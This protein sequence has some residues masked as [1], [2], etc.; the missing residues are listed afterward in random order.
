MPSAYREMTREDRQRLVKPS[1]KV[2]ALPKRFQGRP[3]AWW[4]DKIGAPFKAQIAT[5]GKKTDNAREWTAKIFVT[6]FCD[7]FYKDLNSEER[8][9]YELLIGD[10]VY[11]YLS[12]HTSR[13][14]RGVEPKPPRIKT[15]GYAYERWTKQRPDEYQPLLDAYLDE[16]PDTDI[17]SVGI[18]RKVTSNLFKANVSKEDQ[19]RYREEAR[20]AVKNGKQLKTLTDEARARYVDEFPKRMKAFMQEAETCAGIQLNVQ[21]FAETTNGNHALTTFLSDAIKDFRKTAAMNQLLGSMKQWL[22]VTSGKAVEPGVPPLAVYGDP[23]P[24]GC[25]RPLLP[26]GWPDLHLAELQKL[27]RSWVKSKW[28]HQGGAG[29]SIPWEEIWA[30]V[31]KW[32]DPERLPEGAEWK[33]P[34]SMNVAQLFLFLTYV[35]DCEAGVI[36]ENKQIQFRRVI[37]GSSPIDQSDSQESSREQVTRK[38]KLVYELTFE[39]TVTRCHAPGGMSYP[40]ESLDY[41]AFLVNGSSTPAINNDAPPEWLGLPTNASSVPG[42]SVNPAE[43]AALDAWLWL[44]PEDDRRLA[45]TLLETYKEFQAHLP[46][47]T[48]GGIWSSKSELPALFPSAAPNN[49]LSVDFFADFW[50]PITYYSG[51]RKSLKNGSFLSFEAWI[52]ETFESKALLH[53][54]SSTLHGGPDDCIWILRALL[55][56]LLNFLAVSNRM[57]PPIELP[58]EYDPSRLPTHELPRLRNWILD[59]TAELSRST[60]ILRKT[61][62]DRRVGEAPRARPSSPEEPGRPEPASRK[63]RRRGKGKG[64]KK[65]V[66]KRVKKP[67]L[68][69]LLSD[70]DEAHSSSDGD[71]SGS[72][73]WSDLDA[74]SDD[75]VSVNT[76]LFDDPRDV[77]ELVR[78]PGPSKK[79]HKARFASMNQE[80]ED[81]RIGISD[82]PLPTGKKTPSRNRAE[83]SAI[84]PTDTEEPLPVIYLDI[85]PKDI[86]FGGFPDLPRPPR[87]R[88]S[89]SYETILVAMQKAVYDN[90][91]LLAAFHSL[92]SCSEEQKAAD[93]KRT[94]DLLDRLPYVDSGAAEFFTRVWLNWVREEKVAPA[95]IQCVQ[96]LFAASQEAIAISLAAREVCNHLRQTNNPLKYDL[97][98]I[99][100]LDVELR[101]GLAEMRWTYDEVLALG[102]LATAWSRYLANRLQWLEVSRKW[103]RGELPENPNY[104]EEFAEFGAIWHRTN[105]KAMNR[106]VANRE[107]YWEMTGQPWDPNHTTSGFEFMFGNPS[108]TNMIV[109]DP[110]ALDTMLNSKIKSAAKI[111]GV[112]F[113]YLL[114]DVTESHSDADKTPKMAKSTTSDSVADAPAAAP[115]AAP[116]LAVDLAPAPVPAPAADPAPTLGGQDIA[117]TADVAAK[118]PVRQR[119]PKPRPPPADEDDVAPAAPARDATNDLARAAND[120][121]PT[122][123]KDTGPSNAAAV[124]A[125]VPDPAPVV[126]ATPAS[127]AAASASVTAEPASAA[128]PAPGTSPSAAS[129]ASAAPV[130][131][132]P[133]PVGAA[134][135]I[136]EPAEASAAAPKPAKGRAPARRTSATQGPAPVPDRVMRSAMKPQQAAI[137]PAPTRAQTQKRASTSSGGGTATKRARR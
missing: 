132:D 7:A 70:D 135:A 34:S 119:R 112:D 106:L 56:L 8:D 122:G 18:R 79:S 84:S 96:R 10:R 40:P 75:D 28:Q 50:L 97:N 98:A 23:D 87:P 43:Q 4:N 35:R 92:A 104:F 12:N 3:K 105:T 103:F 89:D 127:P 110:A 26:P 27:W 49:P 125:A 108:V 131:I 123:L 78:S 111:L 33:D 17:S 46:A 72:E 32:I 81:E 20:A 69:S 121:A 65:A 91:I 55:K 14:T 82:I 109:S 42:A 80:D 66:S 76:P 61:S 11:T 128:P 53:E 63:R 9:D 85:D 58:E 113:D 83:F 86:I 68:D 29:K 62:A 67:K 115:A 57:T 5:R 48:S 77:F 93:S 120:T 100:R 64:K 39:D 51:P 133:E 74:R 88:C 102:R 59:L 71:D 21:M 45:V 1:P 47:S 94:W 25:E 130:A 95:V 99:S 129:A 15:K 117:A 37:A 90:K 136:T 137:T 41:A 24:A 36:P 38:R 31:D 124:P 22:Q 118:S 134:A 101:I 30:N 2:L 44:L 54:P 60:D 116:A 6:D 13:G 19:D 107:T 52:D 114:V 126:A 16:H 73:N